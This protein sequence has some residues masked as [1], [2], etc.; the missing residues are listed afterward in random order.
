[1]SKKSFNQVKW[2][3]FFLVALI[4]LFALLQKAFKPFSPAPL[5]GYFE[6]SSRPDPSLAGFVTGEFQEKTAP[7]LTG[8][9]DWANG[10]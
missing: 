2:I 3:S 10:L 8:A 1:M 7:I 5:K 6:P 9:S 4:F